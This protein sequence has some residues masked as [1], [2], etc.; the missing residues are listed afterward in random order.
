MWIYHWRGV[1]LSHVVLILIRYHAGKTRQEHLLQ[2]NVKSA[3]HQTEKKVCQILPIL[4]AD[5]VW[6]TLEELRF[7]QK[8]SGATCIV[9][10]SLWG[11]RAH[12]SQS[13]AHFAQEGTHRQTHMRC[14][15]SKVSLEGVMLLSQW[16]AF[17]ST[18]QFVHSD[19]SGQKGKWTVFWR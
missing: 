13:R 16:Q 14:L 12:C 15:L 1:R 8:R 5:C 9:L 7:M 18:V 17:L 2:R 19:K 10:E 3:N 4:M 11:R 6:L